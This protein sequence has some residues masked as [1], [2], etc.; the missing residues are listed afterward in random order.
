MNKKGVVPAIAIILALVILIII[1]VSYAGRECN[2]NRD[3]PDNAY[4]D[5]QY[6]CRQY[7]EQVVLTQNTY[8]P[9]AIVLGLSLIVAAFIV[10][11]TKF[12]FWK[13]N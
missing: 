7:P 3:C 9:A 11:G 12:K 8:L 2:S 5:S 6:D 10:R 13:K 1:L 4:C